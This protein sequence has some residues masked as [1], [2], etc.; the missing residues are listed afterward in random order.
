MGQKTGANSAPGTM[1][2]HLERIGNCWR[3]RLSVPS[4]LRQII[5]KREFRISLKTADLKE[6]KRLAHAEAL[7]VE[8]AFDHARRML[9]MR[10]GSAPQTELTHAEGDRL[11]VCK[12][13]RL[14]R[15]VKNLCEISERLRAKGVA[16]KILSMN[17]D[18]GTPTGK[19]MLHLLGSIAEFEREIM[20][21]RQKEGVQRAKS[22]GLYKGRAPVVRRQA[23]R[24]LGMLQ[25][26]MTQAAIARE[27]GVSTRSIFR[28]MKAHD[29]KK[30]CSVPARVS[31]AP[32]TRIRKGPEARP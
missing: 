6:A 16:L 2:E 30:S 25:E 26:G 19:L 13:D 4:A 15:S 3:F 28:I 12:L 7:K 9:A 20:L 27:L 22:E 31:P 24:I 5:G 17:I 10:A 14:A 21:E 8:A 32:V 18:T 23:D 11:I 29:V 1:P